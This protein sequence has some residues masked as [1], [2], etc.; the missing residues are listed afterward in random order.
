MFLSNLIGFMMLDSTSS[1]SILLLSAVL[2]IKFLT[3]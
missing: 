3:V 1:D 2:F